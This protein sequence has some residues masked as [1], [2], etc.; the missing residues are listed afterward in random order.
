MAFCINMPFNT[1][2]VMQARVGVEQPMNKWLVRIEGMVT[3]ATAGMTEEQL[4]WHPEGKWSSAQVLE[5]LCKTYTGTVLGYQ[6]AMATNRSLTPSSK[7]MQ[8]L[9]RFLLLKLGYFPS[10]GKSPERVLPKGEWTGEYALKA[11]REELAKL[12]DA[13]R[14]IEQTSA[15][16]KVVSHPAF[17]PFTPEEWARFHYVHAK[18]HMKQVA[19]LRRQMA[20][21]R[22]ASA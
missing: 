5:H 2:F 20:T 18:H 7:G 3:S 11:L 13:Q 6:K 10:G 1:L 17:G 14:K 12:I 15:G 22:S 8:P 4:A 21:A 16:V 19:A 9:A